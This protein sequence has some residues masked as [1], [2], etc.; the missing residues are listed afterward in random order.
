MEQ[1][2]IDV[3]RSLISV[4]ACV[5]R[6]SAIRVGDDQVVCHELQ[7]IRNEGVT[8]SKPVSS[9]PESAF[10]YRRK[11]PNQSLSSVGTE[12]HRDRNNVVGSN[13]L[14]SGQLRQRSRDI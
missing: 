8:G 7:I 4:C 5:Y 10:Y 12:P 13:C 14:E 1:D 3:V 11:P 6:G 2:H 9:A